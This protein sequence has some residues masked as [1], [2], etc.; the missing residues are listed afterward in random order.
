LQYIEVTGRV[1][2]K[3][4]DKKEMNE[5]TATYNSEILNNLKKLHE[6]KNK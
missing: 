2:G 1:V 6:Y 3:I 4:E 5:Y